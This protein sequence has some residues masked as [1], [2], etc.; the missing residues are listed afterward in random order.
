MS[1]TSLLPGPSFLAPCELLAGKP[2][3]EVLGSSCLGKCGQMAELKFLTWLRIG[4]VML[5]AHKE[6][7]SLCLLIVDAAT[8]ADAYCIGN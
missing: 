8:L 7:G 2:G 6:L 1:H 5:Q 3:G 4:S